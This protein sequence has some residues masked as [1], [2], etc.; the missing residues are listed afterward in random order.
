MFEDS[1]VESTGRIR[2]RSRRY[3]A[4]SF[5]LETA[6]VAVILAIPY[7][8]PDALPRKFLAVPLI[9]PPPAPTEPIAAQPAS[10]AASRQPIAI[11]MRVPIRIPHGPVQMNDAPP[12]PLVPGTV[13]LGGPNTGALGAL[14]LGPTTPPPISRV[15]P[16]KPSG[17]LH[18]SSGVAQGQLIV[19]IQPHYPA[20]AMEAR[21]QGTVVVS[22]LISTTGHI[23]SLRVLSG[24][25][26][27]VNAAVDAI[28]Q[29][30]YRPW[31]LNGEPVEVETTINVVFSLGDTH[32]SL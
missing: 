28:R 25:P 7:V 10:R 8:Y 5:V 3:A 9:A 23:E 20:I 17:P 26:L 18:V 19:P 27:L 31:T 1:L 11:D 6:L 29:A 24:P 15:H 12:G 2:T 14:P 16:A 13:N 4:G 32:A 22:A 21:V 30:R